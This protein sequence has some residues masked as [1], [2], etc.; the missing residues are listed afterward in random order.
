[1]HEARGY[2]LLVA[3][4][5]AAVVLSA[6]GQDAGTSQ[7]T[8]RLPELPSAAHFRS[9]V[10]HPY[11]PL[12]AGSRWVYV[13]RT[14]DGVERTVVTVERGTRTVAGIPATVVHDRATL[15][16]RLSE[17]THDWFAQDD[18]GNVWYLGE[19]TTAYEPGKKPSKEGSWEAGVNGA[20]P[21]IA[22]PGR[23]VAGDRY[24]QEYL[25]GTAEDRGEV[26][27]LDARG[28]VPWGPFRAAVKTRDTTPLEPDLVEYKYYVRDVGTVLEEEG[29]DR[30]ELVSFTP[31]SP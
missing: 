9:T 21:G 19:D 12:A 5:A 2:H 7:K 20:R 24:Q 11:L 17:D 13:S 31:G 25:R 1:V 4:A 26:M 16:G 30:V 6:C 15:N 27:A 3:A 14:A 23:P 18:Q 29:E 22:M 28:L 8:F 10:D